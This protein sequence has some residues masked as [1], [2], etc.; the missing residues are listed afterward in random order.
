MNMPAVKQEDVRKEIKDFIVE[1]FL[2][3]S[4]DEPF[5]DTDSFMERGII[6]STGILELTSFVE[7]KYGI[8]IEDD[9]MIPDNLDSLS[10][11]VNFIARKKG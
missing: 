4:E 2:F 9:E 11:L 6:D 10:N 7:E 8:K 3:G 1:T 5:G